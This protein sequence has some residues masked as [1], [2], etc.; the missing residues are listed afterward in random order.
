MLD[1]Y[2]YTS[3]VSMSINIHFS[4]N[5]PDIHTLL[6]PPPSSPPPPPSPNQ[7]NP[8]H[9]HLSYVKDISRYKS[10]QPN[11]LSSNHKRLSCTK[12][13]RFIS[14]AITFPSEVFPLSLHWGGKV[15]LQHETY[16]ATNILSSMEPP[17]LPL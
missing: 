17:N 16:Q 9:E 2:H 13:I 3:I 14:S 1:K 15:L 12:D 7:S 11:Q 10:G 8:N 5:P 4:V 6:Q